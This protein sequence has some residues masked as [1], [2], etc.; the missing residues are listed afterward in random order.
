MKFETNI[1][2][3]DFVNIDIHIGSKKGTKF[4][5]FL[6]SLKGLKKGFGTKINFRFKLYPKKD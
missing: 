2:K 6:E 4:F 5:N 1:A 3:E